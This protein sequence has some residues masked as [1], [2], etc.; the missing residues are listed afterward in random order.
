M[1]TTVNRLLAVTQAAREAR[2]IGQNPETAMHFLSNENVRNMPSAPQD[3]IWSRIQAIRDLPR[4][5]EKLSQPVDMRGEGMSAA[6]ALAESKDLGKEEL[7]NPMHLCFAAIDS[8]LRL[9]Q[10]IGRD[11]IGTSFF[12]DL[13]TALQRMT[14]TLKESATTLKQWIEA[15]RRMFMETTT[16]IGDNLKFA[17][18][19]PGDDQEATNS[20]W[21][22]LE[23]QVLAGQASE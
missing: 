20:G 4:I 17:F 7:Y 6:Q 16:G 9:E 3:E 2:R 5:I 23:S 14:A 10:Q 21:Q 12:T 19:L 8:I 13:E 11:K 15:G 18:S 1:S 22:K